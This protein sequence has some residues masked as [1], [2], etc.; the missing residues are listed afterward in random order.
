MQHAASMQHAAA[1]ISQS[2][3]QTNK[4]R[5]NQSKDLGQKSKIF[6]CAAIVVFQMMMKGSI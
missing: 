2:I 6:D 3:K 5:V 4:Q 1:T